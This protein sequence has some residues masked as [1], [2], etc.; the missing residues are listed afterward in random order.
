MERAT[1]W[2]HDSRNGKDAEKLRNTKHKTQDT[3][4]KSQII[5]EQKHTTTDDTTRG[6]GRRSF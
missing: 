6:E 4:H 1:E 5:K 2:Q 3:S